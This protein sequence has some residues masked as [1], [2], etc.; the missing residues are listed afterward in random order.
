MN[1]SVTLGLVYPLDDV[2]VSRFG[3][4]ASPHLIGNRVRHWQNALVRDEHVVGSLLR[5]EHEGVDRVLCD[6]F[7]EAHVEACIT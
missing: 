5:P 2:L 1:F 7:V 4:D 6:L 3:F